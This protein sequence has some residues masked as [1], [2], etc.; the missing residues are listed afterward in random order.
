M[1]SIINY[2]YKATLTVLDKCHQSD[3]LISLFSIKSQYRLS[4][5]LLNKLQKTKEEMLDFFPTEHLQDLT[6]YAHFV[7]SLP[8]LEKLSA[9]YDRYVK[10]EKIYSVTYDFF[11]KK[12]R[13]DFN[14]FVQFVLDTY[15]ENLHPELIP[16]TILKHKY[17]LLDQNGYI[18]LYKKLQL[19]LNTVVENQIP[20]YSV[21]DELLCQINNYYGI[22]D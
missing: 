3:A 17:V 9:Y 16:H 22:K 5:N 19:P 1:Y 13:K 8:P 21:D 6:E 4:D 15:Y 14:E 10:N 11:P 20:V 12:E 2:Q 18:Q 7:F